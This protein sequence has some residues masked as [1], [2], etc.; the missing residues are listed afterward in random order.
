M[1]CVTRMYLK[2]CEEWTADWGV[3]G[4][5]SQGRP[6]GGN[7]QR[8]RTCVWVRMSDFSGTENK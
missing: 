8:K 6:F 2:S 5:T 4:G 7:N 1:W 3:S